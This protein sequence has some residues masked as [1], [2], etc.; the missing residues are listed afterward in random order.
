VPFCLC[1]SRVGPVQLI[2][3]STV[4]F[5]GFRCFVYAYQESN[6]LFVDRSGFTMHQKFVANKSLVLV[7][8]RDLLLIV[9]KNLSKN[10]VEILWAQNS[11]LYFNSKNSTFSSDF[12]NFSTYPKQPKNIQQ[13]SKINTWTNPPRKNK[14]GRLQTTRR[15]LKYL[16]R[17]PQLV[18]HIGRRSHSRKQTRKRGPRA[19]KFGRSAIAAIWPNRT[20]LT[21]TGLVPQ[22]TLVEVKTKEVPFEEFRG[23]CALKKV[24][25][26]P[27]CTPN[28]HHKQINKRGPRPR[29]L[30]LFA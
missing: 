14:Y 24:H 13:S 25:L 12:N 22:Q 21:S 16:Q 2:K 1:P 29:T 18:D 11:A 20:S 28:L 6:P 23:C 17:T 7:I 4:Q 3:Q 8:G 27:S 9:D 26:L 5:H 10:W 30:R 15:K 19:S